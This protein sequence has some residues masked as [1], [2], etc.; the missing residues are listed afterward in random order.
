MLTNVFGLFAAYD[1]IAIY[2]IIQFINWAYPADMGK[3]HI[4]IKKYVSF[5]VK[6]IHINTHSITRY[7]K[8]IM[9]IY[10]M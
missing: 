2:I 4:R 9:R 7:D 8:I 5:N 3:S 1:S 10:F 6:S